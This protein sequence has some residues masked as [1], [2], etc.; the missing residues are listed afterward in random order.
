MIE[1]LE[2]LSFSPRCHSGSHPSHSAALFILL[3]QTS[4]LHPDTGAGGAGFCKIRASEITCVKPPKA[5]S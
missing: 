1:P 2:A 4:E 3:I 5:N